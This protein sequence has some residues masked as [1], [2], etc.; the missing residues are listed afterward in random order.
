[1]TPLARPRSLY[2]L[3]ISV[4]F[5]TQAVTA[6]DWTQFRGP[7]GNGHSTAKGLPTLWNN[8]TNVTWKTAIPGQGWSSPVVQDGQIYLT[9]AVPVE[10][11]ETN[12]MEL[13]LLVVEAKNG[14]LV[15]EVSLFRQDGS[16]APGIHGK[17]SHASPTPILSADRVF[18]H[19]GHQGTACVTT[20]GDLLWKN[21][22]I[23]YPPVHGNG[24]SPV[25]VDGK[26]IFSCDGGESPFVVALNQET[27]EIDW[28]VDRITDA[29]RSFSFTTPLVI[30]V[31]DQ[32]QVISPG[33][34]CVCAFDPQDGHEIWRCNY[35]EG[36]SVIPRPVF[37]HGLVYVCTGYG[38]PNLLAIRPDGNGDVTESHVAW[39]INKRVPHTP[40]LLVVNDEL[41]MVSDNGV[42]SCLNAQ[43]GEVHWQERLEKSE[44]NDG[45]S[46]SPL[47]ADGRIYFQSENGTATVVDA[48]TNFN[49]VAVNDLG[50]RTLASYG[51][52][53][54]A[55]LIRSAQHLFCIESP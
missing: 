44:G 31:N 6:E 45:F 2:A 51:V 27:G 28:K 49:Q 52:M 14:Q 26:V 38:S 19:F 29:S 11:S 37:A 55:L 1:M 32:T 42:A 30:Q 13:T 25:L 15:K 16:T 35:G 17:N 36:Y 24:G 12:D 9:A 39:E 40:S 22:S 8:D 41:Y 34:G 5:F 20:A 7:L 21:D 48:D 46:A 18:V 50:E 53:H 47:Y 33:S 3:L 54:S 4:G 23:Q 10:E 43:T